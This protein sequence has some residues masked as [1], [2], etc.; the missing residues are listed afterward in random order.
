MM[1][2]LIISCL[3]ALSFLF[4]FCLS[5]QSSLDRFSHPPEKR[6][7]VIIDNDFGG[8][9]DGLFQLAH[10]LLSPTVDVRGIIGSKNYKNGFYNVPGTAEYASKKAEALLDVMGLA[11]QYLVIPGAASTLDVEKQKESPAAKAIVKEAMREDTK[12]PLYVVCGGGLTNIANAY[13]MNPEIAERLTLIWIGGE[14]YKDLAY[15]PPG[16]LRIE[17]NTGIDIKA[18]QIIFNQSTIPMWQVPRNAYR[19][20]L[21]SNAEMDYKVKE[22]S[23]LGAYLVGLLED[24]FKR[25]KY[26][27]GEAYVLGDNPLVLLTALQSSWELDPSSSRYVLKSA[28]RISEKGAYIHS[29][30]GRTIRVYTVIDTRLMFEDMV[31]KFAMYKP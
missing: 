18:A 13:L 1:N 31:A 23:N 2:R 6:A 27:L 28:P 25:A 3:I 17:Y 14:E 11:D 26:K 5:G 9:P 19:Q 16:K 4:N 20:T 29:E 8:D 12:Q 22:K 7:R 15:P 30:A 21:V 10:H 24:L